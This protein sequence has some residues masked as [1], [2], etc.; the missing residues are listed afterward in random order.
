MPIAVPAKKKYSLLPLLTVLF[1]FSYGLMTLLIVEQGSVIQSQRNL[2]KVLGRDSSELWAARGKAI[3]D[4]ESARSQS[5]KH[6]QAP[7][8][9][10][11]SSES[12]LFKAPSN[13][14]PSNQAPSN[15]APSSQ[16]P[17][18]QA[19]STQV[20]PQ[21]RSQTRTG[22]IAKPGTQLPPMPAADL[23]DRRRALNTI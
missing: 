9:Q 5:Q 13:Q 15:Q 12:P 21:H 8:T 22:K 1:V 11:P 23:S 17:S 16:A 4:Q 10:A 3:G 20:A 6:T 18:N 19:P 2:I 7:S 14:A